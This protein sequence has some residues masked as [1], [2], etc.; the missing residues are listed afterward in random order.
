V[1]VAGALELRHLAGA[2]ERGGAGLAEHLGHRAAGGVLGHG[3]I[4]RASIE[5]HA[6]HV[7]DQ[8]LDARPGHSSALSASRKASFATGGP[9]LTRSAFSRS[10]AA[11]T[12][13]ISTPRSK[14]ARCSSL[15]GL[16]SC[17]KR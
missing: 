17:S 3:V 15:A 10:R 2:V 1:E 12:L 5:E 6:V 14:S 11:D 13:R 7:E 16:R 8:G 9:M 4:A